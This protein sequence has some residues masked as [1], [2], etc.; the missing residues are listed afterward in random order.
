[1]HRTRALLMANKLKSVT[2]AFGKPKRIERGLNT[3]IL[4]LGQMTRGV[5]F[6]IGREHVQALGSRHSPKPCAP[7]PRASAVLQELLL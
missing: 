4:T 1:M 2:S 7:G 3:V 6:V 5:I